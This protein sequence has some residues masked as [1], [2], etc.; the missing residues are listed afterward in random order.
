MARL[1]KDFVRIENNFT[2][3]PNEILR[4]KEMKS[5]TKNILLTMFGLPSDWDFS[6]AGISTCVYEG[7]ETVQKSLVELE[8][9]GYI[10]RKRQRRENGTLGA[11]IYT[12]HQFP[13]AEDEN[14]YKK[15]FSNQDVKKPKQEK[16]NVGE[17]QNREEPIQDSKR[18][19]R[20]DNKTSTDDKKRNDDEDKNLNKTRTDFFG[21]YFKTKRRFKGKGR[22]TRSEE[23]VAGACT[24]E[25]NQV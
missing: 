4:N 6:I 8:K 15:N 22:Y 9:L 16:T 1:M 5:S 20:K 21:R 19:L 25:E 18:Q 11:M 23:T 17:N 7:Y 12:I 2:I 13:V 14:T 10:T 3:I 24:K